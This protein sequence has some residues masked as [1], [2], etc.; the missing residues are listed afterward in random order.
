[1]RI[2]IATRETKA[3]QARGR[4]AASALMDAGHEVTST[5]LFT[6]DMDVNEWISGEI[7]DECLKDFRDIVKSDCLLSIT[8][9]RYP[10]TLDQCH[11]VIFGAALAF[12]KR[13]ALIGPTNS[14]FHYMTLVENYPDIDTFIA[15][16]KEE[17]ER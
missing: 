14:A 13:L 17:E 9:K 16:L 10:G 12:N 4:K 8:P 2:Y 3:E 5:W 15:R 11:P 1:M 7:E 6:R